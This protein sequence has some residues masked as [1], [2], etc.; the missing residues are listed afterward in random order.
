MI[1][2]KSLV[3]NNRVVNHIEAEHVFVG[4]PATL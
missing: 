2:E 4:T 3:M 1:L